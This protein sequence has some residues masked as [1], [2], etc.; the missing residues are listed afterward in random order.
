[1]ACVRFSAILVLMCALPGLASAADGDAW[2]PPTNPHIRLV[3]G[4]EGSGSWQVTSLEGDEFTLESAQRFEARTGD[5]FAVN[6]RIRVGIDTKALPELVSYDERGVEIA[7]RP[8]LANAPD[9]F[10]T[11][12]QHYRRVFT[13]AP[14]AASVR[15]RIRGTGGAAIE[16]AQFEFHRVQVN[17][18]ET[19]MLVDPTYASLRKGVMLESNFGI[20][21][22]E[23]VSTGDRDGD[24]RWAL[25][26]VD[27]DRLTEP[28]RRGEDWRSRF[29]YNPGAIFWSD[30]AVL[31]SDT[32]PEDSL[33]DR[34]RALHY[35]A[36]VHPGP[37]RVRV[38]DPGRAVALSLDGA[39]WTRHEGGREID[40]GVRDLKEG[41]VEFWLDACYRDRVSV[42]PIYFDYVRLSPAANP[43]FVET[44]VGRAL[45]KPVRRLRG[46]VDEKAVTITVRAPRYEEAASWPV[47]CGLP[48]PRGELANPGWVAVETAEGERV[49]SQ[50]RTLATWPDG[51][52]KWLALD[53]R[54]PF[55]D[56]SEG[57]YRVVYGNA[58]RPLAGPDRVTIEATADGLEVDTGAIRFRVPRS[59][60]GI[61]EDVRLLGGEL[62]QSAP[63]AAEIVESGGRRWRALDQ[64]VERLEVEQ[65]GP[66]HAVI[67]AATA[68][69]PSGKPASGFAHRARIHAYAGS[70][71]VQ[72][73]YFVANTDSRP[74]RGVE[75]SMASKVA[76]RSISLQIP[77]NRP[78]A[79]VLT[80]LGPWGA[81]GALV[82]Q[83]EEVAIHS[84][85][86]LRVMLRG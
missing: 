13:V 73:D 19:G 3:G 76:V 70:P 5:T 45:Q 18:Y 60:F 39:N 21:N 44:L 24:G 22:A 84:G 27:L 79:R 81:A 61:V 52:V 83:S 67:L 20:L 85:R 64:P 56:R 1:M 80:P 57:S 54:H 23:R 47:R 43:A 10:S 41:V 15:A 7:G 48:I 26:T 34:F 35:R 16:L 78:V 28:P 62:V 58:V 12:W 66:L 69:P 14:G 32:V 9:N 11:N 33:P 55:A 68:L 63:I 50:A 72:V 77:P 59:R 53:F 51:S 31:K 46:S 42:G 30:G 37:Y 86:E 71:L 40:L 25:I 75:G 74:A 2:L 65:A 36:R 17:S 4:P 29:E 8:A 38:S 82:Q 49:P 6:V